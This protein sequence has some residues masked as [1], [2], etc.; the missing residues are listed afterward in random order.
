MSPRH[1]PVPR[2]GHGRPAHAGLATQLE[3]ARPEIERRLDAIAACREHLRRIEIEPPIVDGPAPFWR[4]NWLPPFDA[5]ALY[6]MIRTQRPRRYVEV[7]SGMSTRFVHRAVRDHGLPTTITSIDP[8]PR[9]TVDSICDT[10]VRCPLEEADLDVFAR[11]DAG[12]VLFVDSSH[13]VLTNSD[14]TVVF[15]DVLPNLKPGVLVHFHDI[16]LPYDYPDRWKHW[17]FNEQ[18]LLASVL[19]A[20]PDRFEVLLPSMFASI[21]PDLSR[22]LPPL[23]DDLGLAGFPAHGGSFWM[24]V[25]A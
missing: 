19:L 21:H 7:G 4:N 13:R 5:A 15:M 3:A 2:Y 24:R 9:A 6:S 10:V 20:A 8:Q 1:E 16:W 23:W 18:Y 11:L 22:V 17:Y 25:V 14:V 12:D